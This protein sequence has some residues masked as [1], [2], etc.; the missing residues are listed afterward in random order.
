V[1]L[2]NPTGGATLTALKRCTVTVCQDDEFT[3]MLDKLTG[4]IELRKSKFVVGSST[5]SSQFSDALTIEGE[6]DEA[7]EDQDPATMDYVMHFL[8]I[9]WKVLF[10]TC[11][12][13]DY[14]GGWVCFGVAISQIGMLTAITFV[15]LGTSLPDTFA[16]V[17]AAQQDEYAD[18][19]VGNVVGSNSVN[20]FLGLGLPWV[21]G[22]IYHGGDYPFPKGDLELS[23]LV[24]TACALTCFAVL[25]W[26]RVY[27]EGELGGPPKA[28][29]IS[30]GILVSLW[31][32]Y[33]TCASM[34]AY[35][36]LG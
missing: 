15:A 1:L 36:M 3:G 29:K 4:L 31:F 19:S 17:A 11:P 9:P 18:A 14:F 33:V 13:T 7:G 32:I 34:K 24:F 23:V 20:V 26:R 5:W 25:T 16:S 8:T 28:K 2:T 21:I 35:G 12:P 22:S 30:A 27:C 10:A 6:V